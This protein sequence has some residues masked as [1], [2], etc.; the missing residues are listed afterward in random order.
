MAGTLMRGLEFYNR[1]R[2][3]GAKLP[4]KIK[5]CGATTRQL[6]GETMPEDLSY[7]LSKPTEEE[8]QRV[9]EAVETEI[10]KAI[11]TY[12]NE[13]ADTMDANNIETLNAPTIRAMAE[14]FTAR[15]SKPQFAGN[16][17]GPIYAP[18]PYLKDENQN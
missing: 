14:Q 15:L 6:I 5:C 16:Y 8:E 10:L 17:E 9:R 1:V 13:V 7:L 4:T 12:L 2:R 11:A 18:H 3:E